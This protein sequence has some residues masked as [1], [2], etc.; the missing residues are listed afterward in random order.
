VYL[1]AAAGTT[2]QPAESMELPIGNGEL[3]L[4]VDDEAA[5]CEVTK[6][7]LETYDYKVLTASDG[8]EAIAVYAQHQEEISVVL[9]DMMMPSMDGLTTIP[10][11]QKISPQVKIIAVSGLASRDQVSAAMG[12]GVKAFLAKPFTAQELLKTIN[13]VLNT[14]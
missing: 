1:P 5:I 11:L 3:I 12:A 10:T 9:M 4:V 14:K 6:T 7:S 8:I 2:T 13:S